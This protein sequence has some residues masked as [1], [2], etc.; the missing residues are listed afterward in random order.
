MTEHEEGREGLARGG[1][2]GRGESAALPSGGDT[3]APALTVRLADGTIAEL[4][5]GRND[6]PDGSCLYLRKDGTVS[7][8]TAARPENAKE[9]GNSPIDQDGHRQQA[10]PYHWGHA[11][12]TRHGA[13]SQRR[14]DPLADELIAATVE[15][16]PFLA[17]PSFGPAL[18][19]WAR[20][21]AR[22][23]LLD[24]YLTEHGLLDGDGEP[25][26]AADLMTKMENLALKHRTRLG[27]DAASRAGIE[28]SLTSTAASQAGLE[29]ALVAG[30]EALRRRRSGAD[31]GTGAG[32]EPRT[33]PPGSEPAGA[34]PSPGPGLPA[35]QGTTGRSGEGAAR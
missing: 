29:A 1:Q 3:P 9:S 21:E 10:S 34:L 33:A 2:A 5:P 20:A 19:A 26:P 35:A 4:R 11:L 14:V 30:A 31:G 25:R 7:V 32:Q 12:S 8:T 23:A 13:H 17:E 27:L 28:A 24:E 16:A 15:S 22:C 6:Q 18:R